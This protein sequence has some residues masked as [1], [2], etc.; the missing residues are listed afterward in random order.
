MHL[1]I[2]SI[3]VG[4]QKLHLIK[5]LN[6]FS[7]NRVTFQMRYILMVKKAN[8]IVLQKGPYNT[9]IEKL[10]AETVFVTS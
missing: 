6:D 5:K 7:K 8:V 2:L 1:I 3:R 10:K 9:Y 4:T